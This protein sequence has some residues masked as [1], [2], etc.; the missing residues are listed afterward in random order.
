MGLCKAGVLVCAHV[1]V[2]FTYMCVGSEANASKLTTAEILTCSSRLIKACV[3]Y[4]CVI[5]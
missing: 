5:L 4:V 3:F 2:Y 1:C